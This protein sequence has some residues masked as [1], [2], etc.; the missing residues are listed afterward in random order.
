MTIGRVKWFA[1]SKYTSKDNFGWYRFDGRHKGATAIHRRNEADAI[2]RRPGIC[3]QCGK[4]YER[5]QRSSSRFCSP[6]CKQS[7]W[8]KRLSVTPSVTP[9]PAPNAL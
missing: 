1:D 3:E 8:C 5:W 6:A 4:R 7:A 2:P 9:A